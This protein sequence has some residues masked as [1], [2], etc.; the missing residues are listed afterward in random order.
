[1][2]RPDDLEKFVAQ[3]LDNSLD[4]IDQPTAD[5]LK[6][7]RMKALQAAQQPQTESGETRNNLVQLNSWRHW[8]RTSLSL[9]ASLLLAAPLWYFSSSSLQQP[10]GT[11]LP[12][13]VQLAVSEEPQLNT[14][15]L[16]A[17]FAELEDDELDMVEDLD[18][19]LWLVEQDADIN[20]NNNAVNG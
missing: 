13:T 14:L 2:N 12:D 17:T 10:A 19:A 18:F 16:V 8:P 1:M 20:T 9:A 11:V 15:D 6:A 7:A 3:Q 5:K 4:D